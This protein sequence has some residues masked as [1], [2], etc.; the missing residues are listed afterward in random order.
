[1]HKCIYSSVS[2]S[3]IVLFAVADLPQPPENLFLLKVTFSSV[4]LAWNSTGSRLTVPVKSYVVQ[5][6]PNGSSDSLVEMSVTK[7]EI[8]VDGLSA[9]TT[10]EFNIFAVGKFGRSLSAASTV[11][12]TS[13]SSQTGISHFAF[14]HLVRIVICYVHAVMGALSDTVICLSVCPFLCLMAQLP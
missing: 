10:Y 7:P 14:I 6:Q 12:T 5:Y 13:Q 1:M 2:Q 3:S 11:V 9:R 8:F 4:R